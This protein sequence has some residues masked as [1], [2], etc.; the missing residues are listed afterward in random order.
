MSAP[1]L[2][3]YD[4]CL[5]SVS[6]ILGDIR[7]E[8]PN[9]FSAVP[10][11]I[12]HDLITSTLKMYPDEGFKAH[13]LEP[14][15]LSGQVKQ[16]AL[17]D[18]R[19]EEELLPT[20]R[21]FT[22]CRGLTSLSLINI[23]E[24]N[25]AI[26]SGQL[27]ELLVA[28]KNLEEL[29]CSVVFRLSALRKCRKLR[30]VQLHFTPESA[31]DHFLDDENGHKQTHETLSFFTLCGQRAERFVH[32]KQVAEL[33]TH[34]PRLQSLGQLDVSA[35]FGHLHSSSYIVPEYGLESCCWR[36]PDTAGHLDSGDRFFSSIR[37]AALACP[38]LKEL[39]IKIQQR[40]YQGALSVLHT[41][42]NLTYLEIELDHSKRD[43]QPEISGLL[44]QVGPGLRHLALHR[45][46]NI[47]FDA[48]LKSC[49]ELV[50][51]K[52]DCDRV[53]GDW[54]E[55][56]VDPRQL[57]RLTFFSSDGCCGNNSLRLMLSKCS[58][59]RELFLKN[60]EF[61]SDSFLSK[62]L[63]DNPMALSQ[64]RTACLCDCRL[65][66]EGLRNLLSAAKK[67]DK[68]SVESSKISE[69]DAESLM[70]EFNPALTIIPDY[71]E[72]L[73]EEFFYRRRYVCA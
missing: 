70:R 46:D 65:T 12:I 69:E 4:I 36:E 30:V 59:L 32:F 3:L 21:S 13:Y 41:L 2:R 55:T 72:G 43:F 24:F 1:G 25:M 27:E 49:P 71:D 34:C 28:L 38:E 61:L 54:S 22:V 67:L 50:S 63:K 62:V 68:I 66:K 35:A 29:H 11:F 58:N 73:R 8:S 48:I 10:H 45:I 56:S 37:T 6:R 26:V 9:R 14:L 51:L 60:S 33:L 17:R 53:A 47:E 52:V 16:L 18:L 31:I 57:Q 44:S 15:L 39:V 7:D 64:L 42:R 19:L 5:K 23:C 40:H 20:L